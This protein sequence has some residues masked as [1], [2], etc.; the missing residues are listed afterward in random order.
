MTRLSVLYARE[1]TKQRDWEGVPGRRRTG[2]LREVYWAHRTKSKLR[3]KSFVN[4]TLSWRPDRA[5]IC[6]R[7]DDPG[8][9]FVYLFSMAPRIEDRFDWLEVTEA[10]TTVPV[11]RVEGAMRAWNGNP[12][13]WPV[14]FEEF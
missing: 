9:E 11:S 4:M 8:D 10:F 2:W 7:S 13:K 5:A 14:N 3:R 6:R 1:A 12:N